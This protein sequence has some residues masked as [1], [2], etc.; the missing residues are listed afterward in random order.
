MHWRLPT[1]AIFSLSAAGDVISI[2]DGEVQSDEPDNT[3][4][5]DLFEDVT[6]DSDAGLKF[7]HPLI[8]TLF[9]CRQLL[10]DSVSLKMV[11]LHR[12]KMA[13][14]E[15]IINVPLLPSFLF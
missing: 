4:S 5:T 3:H 15:K 7:L 8:L 10:T 9:G 1:L 6:I 13:M 2:E 11:I 12:D 14:H